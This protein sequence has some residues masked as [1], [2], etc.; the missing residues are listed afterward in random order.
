MDPLSPWAWSG[1][2]LVALTA[3]LGIWYLW[4]ERAPTPLDAPAARAAIHSKAIHTVVDVRDDAEWTA[5]HL[6]SAIHIPGRDIPTVLPHRIPDRSTAILFY[7]RT[8]RRAAAAARTAQALGYSDVYYLADGDYRDLIH[9]VKI[10]N[11]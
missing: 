11:I 2:F 10:L 6:S 8:G 7:C 5:G 9:R 1:I 4:T 3:V